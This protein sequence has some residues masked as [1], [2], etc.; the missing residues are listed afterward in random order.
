MRQRVQVFRKHKDAVK[1][2]TFWGVN[3]GVSW[4]ANGRPLLFDGED[5]PKPAFEA[6]I[7]AATDEQ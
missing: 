2:F 1:L 5:K 6:V 7:R 3:D 4:R